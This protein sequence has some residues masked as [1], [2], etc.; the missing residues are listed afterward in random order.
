MRLSSIFSFVLAAAIATLSLA[1]ISLA[2][3]KKNVEVS[4]TWRYEYELEGQTRKDVLQLNASKDGVVTGTYIGV[5]EKPIELKEML[6]NRY[7]IEIPVMQIDHGIFLRISLNA[8][9]DK[10]DLD[11]LKNALLQIRQNTNLLQ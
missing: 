7:K 3:G 8:Y 1:N 2:Q 10:R 11:I 6:Y 9:N 5:S 4:G